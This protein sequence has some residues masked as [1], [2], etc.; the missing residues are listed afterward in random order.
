MGCV[1]G[2][3]APLAWFPVV[4]LP[5]FLL[6]FLLLQSLLSP[7]LMIHSTVFPA[8]TWT[9]WAMGCSAPHP[10]CSLTLL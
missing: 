4:L 8:R 5:A 10:L 6:P 2:W 7:L 9:W 3:G 1:P